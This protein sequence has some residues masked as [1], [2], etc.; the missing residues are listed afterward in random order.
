MAI[1]ADDI[2]LVCTDADLVRV[3]PG[4]KL[5]TIQRLRK[6]RG[7]PIP[8]I[9]PQLDRKHRYARRDVL[10]YLSRENVRLV[11]AG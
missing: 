10:A 11:R 5:K 7:F 6:H 2:P 4:L 9:L 1:V 3:I 8:E